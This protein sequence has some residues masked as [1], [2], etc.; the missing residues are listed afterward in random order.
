MCAIL[1][2][3]QTS[4]DGN[5]LFSETSRASVWSGSNWAQIQVALDRPL[6]VSTLLSYGR[7]THLVLSDRTRTNNQNEET[8]LNNDITAGKSPLTLELVRRA[9][10]GDV[11]AFAALFHSHKARLYSVCLRT[12]KIVADAE[13]FTQD[14][15]VLAFR[16]LASF[17]GG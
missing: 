10:K 2:K 16:K 14:A 17:R 12:T 11:D 8:L 15:F 5:N 9:R 4:P 3:V 6:S 13:D 7:L 1:A